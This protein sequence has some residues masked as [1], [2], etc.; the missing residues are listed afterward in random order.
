MLAVDLQPPERH[1]GNGQPKIDGKFFTR[2]SSLAKALEDQGGLI[3]WKAKM[4]ALGIA[5]S[6]ELRGLAA[7]TPPDDYRWRDIVERACEVGG[8]SKA[9]DTGTAIH[10]VTEMLD[11]GDEV[12]DSVPQEILDDALAYRK[13]CTAHGL[14]PLAGEVFVANEAMRVAGSFDRLVEGPDGVAR[15]LDIKTIKKGKDAAAAAKWTGLAWSIQTAVYANSVPWC[16][17]RGYVDW[18][19]VGL[20]QPAR[21]GRNAIIAAIPRGSGECFLI[22]IDLDQGLDLA[23]LAC[24]VREARKQR[25][26]TPRL[27]QTEMTT[28]GSS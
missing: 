11:H 18:E 12:P 26:A 16:A 8:G 25:P 21:T 13:A 22:D 20:R 3:T 28:E 1:K 24:E 7:S 9:A 14:T 10:E 15:I 2:A 6:D 17:E 27:P 19:D 4:A 23:S 5:A